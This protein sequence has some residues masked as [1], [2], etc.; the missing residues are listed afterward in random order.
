MLSTQINDQ[1]FP[2]VTTET[3]LVES[4]GFTKQ[5]KHYK[6]SQEVSKL[7]WGTEH[8]R[9]SLAKITLPCSCFGGSQDRFEREPLWEWGLPR[10]QQSH[11][12]NE[13]GLGCG[14][15]RR[16]RHCEFPSRKH[17][18]SDHLILSTTLTPIETK[19]SFKYNTKPTPKESRFPKQ[20]LGLK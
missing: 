15:A 11:P 12:G 13:E 4:K 2:K 18:K 14:R 8:R 10:A 9:A 17:H 16:Q 19:N 7:V 5:R 6:M 3:I 20:Q 1:L